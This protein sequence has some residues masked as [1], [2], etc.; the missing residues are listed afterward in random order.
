MRQEIKD[1]MKM[2]ERLMS[3]AIQ[4]EELW[5]EECQMLDYVLACPEVF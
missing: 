2:S 4:T 5:E 3:L 1:F